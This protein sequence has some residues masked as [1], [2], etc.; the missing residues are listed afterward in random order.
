MAVNRIDLGTLEDATQSLTQS[1]NELN[2]SINGQNPGLD[3]PKIDP[4][5]HGLI[6]LKTSNDDQTHEL[7]T[8]GNKLTG[9]G[10]I[11]VN[12]DGT[13]SRIPNWH[14]MTPAEQERSQRLISA[15]NIRRMHLLKQMSDC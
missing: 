7:I 15:R 13:M 2:D 9:L 11:I 12:S 6:E 10:P 1:G 14:A 8:E 4:K 5:I 3:D